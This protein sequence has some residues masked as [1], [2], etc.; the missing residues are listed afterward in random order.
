[1]TEHLIIKI[2]GKQGIPGEASAEFLASV[3]EAVD[4]KDD[5]E[6]AATAA[7]ASA[8]AAA[9]SAAAAAISAATPV[10]V[11]GVQTLTNKTLTSPVLNTPTIN[12]PS[13]LVK[14]DVGLGNVDNTSDATK[15]AAT[16]TLTNKTLDDPT[17]NT[18]DINGG[19][20]DNLTSLGI[21][22][23][24]ASF[25][26]RFASS[27]VLTGNRSVSWTVNDLNRTINMS[28]NLTLG[29]SFTTSGA[30]AVTLTTT[31]STNV[32]LPATG[33]LATLTGV[34]TLDN[35]TLDDPTISTRLRLLSTAGS[36]STMLQVTE[37]LTANRALT[38]K[39]NNVART[40]DF[41]GNLTIGGALTTAGA[42]TMS[43]AHAFTGTLTGATTVTFPTTG[44]LIAT[45]VD[46]TIETAAVKIVKRTDLSSPVTTD[47]RGW[48]FPPADFNIDYVDESSTP[49]TFDSSELLALNAEAIAYS[50][51]IR[52]TP[53]YNLAKFEW[54]LNLV[55]F[56]GQS[57][58]KGAYSSIPALTTASPYLTKMLGASIR[59]ATTTSTYTPATSNALYDAVA[60]NDLNGTF[61]NNTQLSNWQAAN[62]PSDGSIFSTSYAGENPAIGYLHQRKKL[63]NDYISAM[64]GDDTTRIPVGAC[65]AVADSALSTIDGSGGGTNTTYL[66]TLDGASKV[67]ALTGGGETSG[68]SAVVHLHGEAD[69]AGVEA[70]Y[71]EGVRT[72]SDDIHDDVSVAIFGQTIP[73]TRK[74]APWFLH[75]P[76]KEWA[77]DSYA[78]PN[79]AL[80]LSLENGHFIAVGPY[81]Q[82]PD[83]SDKFSGDDHLLSNGYRAHG[84]KIAQ[85]DHI[86]RD[87]GQGWQPMH[88]FKA[89]HRGN[90]CVVQYHVP[91]G[92]IAFGNPLKGYTPLDQTDKGF[93]AEDDTGALTIE[94]ISIDYS[95]CI[96]FEF[97]RA[98]S[99]TLTIQYADVAHDGRGSITDTDDFQPMYNYEI[100]TYTNPDDEYDP[101]IVDEPYSMRN[102]AWPQSFTST[103]I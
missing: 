3:Q 47:E 92:R 32:T 71:R 14:G 22:S 58:S 62:Y 94:S 70:T 74:R 41:G 54:T 99:G 51:Q 28:G 103:A 27:E 35:K 48:I 85:V 67:E 10:S 24:G 36:F 69:R 39:V 63:W 72:F 37:T 83:H 52:A 21:R 91:F 1:M 38:I 43:G 6:A 33:T 4:A 59:S 16:A 60:T 97:N 93:T 40:L 82:Y 12:N 75:A 2:P 50:A 20:A 7:D 42:V 95:H 29:G 102:W 77:N 30:N 87:L 44:T 84:C 11:A 26:I 25:D 79:A 81:Y 64:G 78:T 46:G 55:L 34:E 49:S 89:V 88:A 68:L 66:R 18:P 90:Y 45:D 17:I 65:P 5:A 80:A 53:R 9:A 73:K 101:A 100:G 23:T 56:L 8:V 19:T 13:G 86:V 96:V 15:N 98:I 57:H 61:L 76:G 31:G